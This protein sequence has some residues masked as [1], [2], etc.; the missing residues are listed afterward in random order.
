MNKNIFKIY[1]LPALAIAFFGFILLNITFVLDAAFQS[2]IF[3]YVILPFIPIELI[4]KNG[5]SFPINHVIFAIFIL[6][7]SWPIL[8]SRWKD[9]YKAIYMVVPT[10]VVLVT[11]G[12]MFWQ[13]PVW[14]YILGGFSVLGT[15]YYFYQKKLPWIYWYAVILISL[16][17]VIGGIFGM[18]I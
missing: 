11:F 1:I 13:T 12:I 7:I 16:M 8:R 3:R 4:S 14:T 10:A 18:E 9:I 5:P 17:L 15:L 6:L 2:T